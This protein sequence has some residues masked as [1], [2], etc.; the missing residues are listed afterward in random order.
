MR[1]RQRK[2]VGTVIL[3]LF[4]LVYSAIASLIG[5]GL[6]PVASKATQL[7]FYR[8]GPPLDLARRDLTAGC[9]G[10]MPMKVID[11]PGLGWREGT[12]RLPG[13]LLH[14]SVKRGPAR[15]LSKCS[16]Y[17][18]IVGQFLSSCHN[19]DCVFANFS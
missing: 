19:G 15:R 14:G 3:L 9:N 13:A 6:L 8:R 7:A 16:P 1:Q 18:Q 12:R 10:R 11:A 2:F 5:A 17:S 4:L